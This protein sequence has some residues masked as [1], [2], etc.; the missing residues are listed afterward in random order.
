MRYREIVK[1]YILKGNV[2]PQGVTYA[3]LYKDK[4]ALEVPTVISN[5]SMAVPQKVIDYIIMILADAEN[6]TDSYNSWVPILEPYAEQIKTV[7]LQQGKIQP[8][9]MDPVIKKIFQNAFSQLTA[10]QV[11]DRIMTNI[12]YSDPKIQSQSD[13]KKVL[14][15]SQ[16]LQKKYGLTVFLAGPVK[17][18]VIDHDKKTISRVDKSA[19]YLSRMRGYERGAEYILI[20]ADFSIEPRQMLKLSRD[21]LKK[22]PDYSIQ[23]KTPEILDIN[24]KM[25]AILNGRG[26]IKA[27]HGTSGAIYKKIQNQ[28]KM[29]PGQ[30]PE[31][32]DKIIGHSD[33]MI[34]FTL[35]PNVARRYGIRAAKSNKYVILEVTLRDFSKLRFDEDSLSGAIMS[36]IDS[37]RRNDLAVKKL[38]PEGW[39]D[40]QGRPCPLKDSYDLFDVIRSTFNPDPHPEL[41]FPNKQ[42]IVNYLLYRA[43]IIMSETSFAYSG[44][45]PVKDIEVYEIAKTKRANPSRDD[46]QD[47]AEVEKAAVAG[48]RPESK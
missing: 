22:Y 37:K 3:Y 14:S 35:D 44:T 40:D 30:G 11:L 2:E 29:I 18:L 47:Y 45:V 31:Y 1:E 6:F 12:Q 13:A 17:Y 43:L 34:Y 16:L 36:F 25:Q 48:Q 8:E 32:S 15:D 9:N 46:E 24:R 26:S 38:F 7:I 21:L 42:K 10:R 39:Y 28:K 20:R 19:Q 27:Y 41:D 33:Q 4:Y 5:T 23:E